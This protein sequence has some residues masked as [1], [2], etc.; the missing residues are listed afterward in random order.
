MT[1]MLEGN[2]CSV[3]VSVTMADTTDGREK[4]KLIRV[5]VNFHHDIQVHVLI[6]CCTNLQPGHYD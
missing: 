4:D 6:L 5:V 2:A 1:K 3:A